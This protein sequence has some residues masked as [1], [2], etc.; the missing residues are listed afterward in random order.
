MTS[1]RVPSLRLPPKK[2]LACRLIAEGATQTK[3][4][5]HPQ[6]NVT[7]QTLTKWA[8]DPDFRA[9][10]EGLRTDLELQAQEIIKGGI[11]DAAEAVVRIAAGNVKV[12][13]IENGQE[14]EVDADS[15][16]LGAR[17]KA[18]LWILESVKRKKLPEPRSSGERSAAAQ[19]D[20][21]DPADAKEWL[22]R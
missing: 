9:R 10:I 14:A 13:I 16:V 22:E 21:A 11:V 8:K 12:K 1:E 6:V 5:A 17:L 15:R 3:A 2:E 19:A 18:A 4:A 20:M 7:K